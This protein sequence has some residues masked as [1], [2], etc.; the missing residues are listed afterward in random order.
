MHSKKLP[1][2]VIFLGTE[3]GRVQ[4]YCTQ[5][6]SHGWA[7]RVFYRMQKKVWMDEI[8]MV[9]WVNKVW[10]PYTK[11]VGGS[12]LLIL[13]K[14]KTHLTPNVCQ[15]LNSCEVEYIPPRYTSK[16]QPMDVG[17]NKPFQDRMRE[18]VEDF[19]VTYGVDK[20]PVRCDISH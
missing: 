18:C 13:D 4:G 8:C 20:K 16:L 10:G 15:L 7:S 12:T 9:D 2:Y 14:A 17:M 6:A 11:Q 5:W 19:M 1:L 3:T